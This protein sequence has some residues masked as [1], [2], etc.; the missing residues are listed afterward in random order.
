MVD[1]FMVNVG[2]YTCHMDPMGISEIYR[3]EKPMVGVDEVL[4]FVCFEGLS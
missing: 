2:K 3:P 1:F 4:C